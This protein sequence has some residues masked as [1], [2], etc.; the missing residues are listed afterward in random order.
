MKP[1]KG[2]E[3]KLEAIRQD[4]QPQGAMVY[5]VFPPQLSMPPPP[6]PAQP[7][8]QNGA[9]NKN[10]QNKNKN[11][12]Q[13]GQ[14][15]RDR[16]ASR[17]RNSRE[18]D[19]KRNSRNGDRKKPSFV[20][21]WPENKAY[22]SKNGNQLSEAFNEHFRDFCFRCGHSSHQGKDCRIYPDRTPIMTLCTRCRQGLHEDCKSKRR[23]LAG[24]AD[25]GIAEMKQ[26]LQAQA[27]FLRGLMIPPGAM[28]G[29][30]AVPA[31]A[32]QNKSNPETETSDED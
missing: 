2:S 7:Q 31:R 1:P 15:S 10:N 22:M 4:S 6:V 24:G 25:K 13:Q 28:A 21:P 11:Q 29:Y 27:M 20:T 30:Q 16:S 14:R 5:P 26:I 19:K 12:Q 3:A 17:G 23:D 32:L 18:D 8:A 9:R